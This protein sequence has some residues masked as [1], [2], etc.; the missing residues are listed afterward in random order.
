[1]TEFSWSLPYSSRRSPVLA[2]NVVA[3]SQPLAAQ[4]GLR[5][6]LA[7]GNAVDAAVA[8]AIA[9]TVV[10]PNNNGVG[11]DAFAILND[12]R[13]LHG[14]NASGRSPA[15]WT[16]ERFAQCET[17]PK[18]GWDAV[19]VP[20]AVSAW[21]ALSERFGKLPFEKLFEPAVDYARRGFPV[22]PVIAESWQSAV[23]TFEAF[24]DW[25]TAFLRGG[26]A[27]RVGEVFA[28]PDLA[29]TL[30]RIAGTRGE[31][32]Y[33]GG[34]AE[35]IV[36]CAARS[37]GAMTLDD[38]ASHRADW[39]EPIAVDYRDVALHEIPPNGQGI[40]ALMMLGILKHFEIAEHRVDSADSVHLQIE[41]MKLA[42]A[43]V[44]RFVADPEAMEVDVDDLLDA[45]YLA[46]RAKRIDMKRAQDFDHG[47]PRKGGTIH[48]TAADADGMMVSLIQSNYNGFGSGIVIPD[49]GIAMQNRGSGFVLTEGH[50]NRVGPRKRPY[51]TIIP[52]FVT[53]DGEPLM[54]FGV[55][56]GPMQPQGHA[57]MMIRIFDYGQNVQAAADA[58]RWQVVEGLKVGLEPG[59][60][61]GT[62]EELRRRGHLLTEVPTPRFGGAQPIM[63]LDDAY[64]AASEPRKDG[65]AVGF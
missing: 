21:V 60:P 8:T 4:A 44:H 26:R 38:L 27:P 10:E 32:F 46:E 56:G 2:R 31:T 53:K 20:G 55:M 3:T 47:C 25:K 41:A 7:G 62:V 9:M 24:D 33:R 48:L 29:R 51:H 50:P 64:V 17:M 11:S 63:R 6:L 58:P 13:R 22:S 49:T 39:V 14:L 28:L 15:A 54:S 5:M 43:D 34:L 30:E 18:R 61:R 36:A 57:Q 35:R 19:T 45:N 12:G 59:F 42:F 65:Q 1:M 40:A 16:P 37:G 23:Q 52:A